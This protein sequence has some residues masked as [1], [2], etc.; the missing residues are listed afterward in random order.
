MKPV[1]ISTNKAVNDK[2]TEKLA[3]DICFKDE[4]DFTTVIFMTEKAQKILR[5]QMELEKEGTLKE[6]V[7]GDNV[8]KIDI[9]N[10]SVRNLMGWAVTHR[11]TM[12][13]N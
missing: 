5:E 11:L 9:D 3:K 13:N 4:G 1:I 8:L 12:E 10:L 2:A 7:Y 6:M